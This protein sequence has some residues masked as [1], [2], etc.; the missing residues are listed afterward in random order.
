MAKYWKNK[1]SWQ[2]D[3]EREARFKINH[4]TLVQC[5]ESIHK[6]KTEILEIQKNIKKNKEDLP[7]NISKIIHMYKKAVG[8]S[9]YIENINK[10]KIEKIK[11][12]SKKRNGFLGAI[13]LNALSLNNLS[14]KEK[15]EIQIIQ[16]R[17]TQEINIIESFD[18]A[19][20][21]V[22][23]YIGFNH[24]QNG[25]GYIAAIKK[26]SN[27]H[28]HP[29][30]IY[31]L[32]EAGKLYKNNLSKYQVDIKLNA[33]SSNFKGLNS[34][35]SFL[36][37]RKSFFDLIG[38]KLDN[39]FS[40][41]AFGF[42]MIR[43]KFD[44]DPYS[45]GISKLRNELKLLKSL[46]PKLK[47]QEKSARIKGYEDRARQG[48]SNLKKNLEYQLKLLNK[49]PYCRKEIAF[50]TCH[51]DHIYPIAKGGLTTK[52]NMVLVC[53][54]CNR[55]KSKSTLRQFAKKHSLNLD[56]IEKDLDLLG[57]DI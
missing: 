26:Y 44:D 27:W 18:K 32:V 39:R 10:N 43:F 19:L 34:L 13:L 6:I 29:K 22:L 23:E 28:N 7:K 33:I 30:N 46:K 54:E 8:Y 9:K 20:D 21:M 47:E 12:K 14:E 1:K 50:E 11:I 24:K 51:A 52:S 5:E 38:L 56:Q 16:D 17:N 15:K 48:S 45:N 2:K 36:A 42:E 40:Q 37:F 57:K 55:S 41:D 4:L 25:E 31:L 3:K 35:K 53:E 49:C